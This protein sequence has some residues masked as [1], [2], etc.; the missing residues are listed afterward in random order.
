MEQCENNA[1]SYIPVLFFKRNNSKVYATLD[2]DIFI[3]LIGG[4]SGQVKHQVFRGK[5]TLDS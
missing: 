3:Q 1:G 4:K 2:A 5:E